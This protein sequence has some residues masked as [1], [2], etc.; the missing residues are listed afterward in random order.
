MSLG[1]V[2]FLISNLLYK[3]NRIETWSKENNL[4][5]FSVK[6]QNL[7]MAAWIIWGC[8]ILLSVFFIIAEFKEK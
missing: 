3:Y 5:Q 6:M 7:I 8:L 4:I 2:I 1:Y